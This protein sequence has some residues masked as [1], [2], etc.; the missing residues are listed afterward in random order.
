MAEQ[1]FE[2]RV[3]G[4]IPAPQQKVWEAFA[5]SSGFANVY[6]GITVEGDWRVGGTVVWS[7]VWEG[8]EFR[9][10]GEISAYEAPRLFEYTYFTSFWGVPRS[11]ETEQRISNAFEPVPGGTR[12]V[13]TQTNIGTAESRDHSAKNWKDILDRVAARL[14]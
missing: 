7:G 11:P 5:T 14:K 12:V 9:D 1:R 13:I 6:E 3:E 2:A 10:E 4:V 8:K